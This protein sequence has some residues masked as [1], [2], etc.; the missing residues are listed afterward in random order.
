M[1]VALDSNI[2]SAL[3]VS[4]TSCLFIKRQ[5]NSL[6]LPE[7]QKKTLY[8]IDSHVLLEVHFACGEVPL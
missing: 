8:S 3:W 4:K 5:D 6:L 1:G 2:P 7:K